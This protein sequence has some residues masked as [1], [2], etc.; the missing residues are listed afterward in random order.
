MSRV[1]VA[2]EDV[3]LATIEIRGQKEC[4]LDVGDQSESFIDRARG[5]IINDREGIVLPGP[6]GDDAIFRI[7]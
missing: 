2:I 6:T 7:K 3:D 4:T 5:R 1:E